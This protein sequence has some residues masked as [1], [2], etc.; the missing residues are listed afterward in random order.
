MLTESL[1][2]G[3]CQFLTYVIIYNLIIYIYLKNK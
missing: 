1:V 3:E 2:L